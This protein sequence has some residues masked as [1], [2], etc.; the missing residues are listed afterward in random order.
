MNDRRRLTEGKRPGQISDGRIARPH[1]MRNRLGLR[2][3]IFS[4]EVGDT[5][6]D[7]HHDP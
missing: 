4:V 2:R 5:L 3:V 7:L 6:W 1:A